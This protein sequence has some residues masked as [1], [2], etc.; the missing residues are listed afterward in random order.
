MSGQN[1]IVLDLETKRTFEDVGGRENLGELGVSL[2][3]VYSYLHG[4]YQA[5]W[6]D[7][8]PKLLSLLVS[9][10]L[11]VGFN[12]K[13]FD[14]PVL[15]PYFKNFD[16]KSLPILDILDELTKTL[17]HRVS[18]DSVAQA[19]LGTRKSGHGLDA[20][21]YWNRKELDKLKKYCLDDVRITK[22]VYEYGAKHGELIFM[23]KFSTSKLKAPV[24]WK[25]Q[26]NEKE[27]KQY[28]LF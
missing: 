28:S 1:I 18:L 2:V 6:E 16:L 5:F 9:K 17:G 27:D 24:S 25:L 7:D 19:T 4:D 3:G 10:P 21:R 15:Q 23:D 11:V 20:I 8:F 12:Q 13:R 22:E 14:L 26:T